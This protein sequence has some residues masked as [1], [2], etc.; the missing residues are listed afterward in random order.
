MT[1][2]SRLRPDRR[3]GLRRASVAVLVGFVVG[4]VA[5]FAGG[6]RLTR[7]QE[8][9]LLAER[10]SE[11]ASLLTSAASG[12]ET[13]L[14][15]LGNVAATASPEVFAQR[16]KL[17]EAAPSVSAV[18]LIAREGGRLVVRSGAG[19]DLPT[20]STLEGPRAALVAR[21]GPKIRM[22]VFATH[23]GQSRFAVVLGPPAA[24]A[25]T[26]IYSE[27]E[28]HPTEPTPVTRSKPFEEVKIALYVGTRA[29]PAKLLVT[30]AKLPFGGLV[31]RLAVPVGG[32]TWFVVGSPRRPL[33]GAL[34]HNVPGILVV[35]TLLVGMA[36]AAVVETIG[37][38]R[39][40]ALVL[41]DERTAALQASLEE[42]ER[43]QAQ[44]VRSERLSALGQMAATVGHEL[45][46]PL[47]AVTNSLYLIRNASKVDGDDRLR[48]QLDTADR[49][50]A[51]ATLI[52]S[53]LLEFSRGRAPMPTSVD[54]DELVSEALSV[55]PPPHGVSVNRS[56]QRPPPL[57]ADRDQ[58]RQVI[59]N[60][61][62]NAYQAM[63]DGGDLAI[64]TA[65]EDDSVRV[66]IADSGAGMDAE[67]RQRLFEPFF[68]R[69]TKGTGLGLAVSKRIIEDH[70]GTISV[71]SEEG[72]GSVFTLQLPVEFMA[73][74]ADN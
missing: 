57:R 54:I 37:R 42:L 2:P 26:A 20:G 53:D 71:A 72:A 29:D 60:V 18:A 30:T 21:A 67:T 47:G 50:V 49:E 1:A 66:T 39:D 68:T 16:A 70:A 58:L 28:L 11:V 31:K 27:Y 32:D 69:K 34:T 10:T 64:T 73:K 22:D 62:S 5:M 43:A 13:S 41:V 12:I 44:L 8:E 40:H 19:R 63:P 17:I 46:N 51:A 7:D 6:T 35:V 33:V 61:V 59:L 23:G 3:L 55:A 65:T 45:R 56:G 24:P 15:S 74:G 48:R 38:H 14:Q 52:V 25:G 36:M 4:S 9:R